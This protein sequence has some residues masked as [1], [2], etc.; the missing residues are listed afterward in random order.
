[1]SQH[2]FETALGRLICDD[3]FRREF[4]DDPE[5]A[6]IC[7][8]FELTSIELHSLCK[9]NS[10]AVDAFVFHVDDRVRRAAEP[11]IE[12]TGVAGPR[13]LPRRSLG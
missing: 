3:G 12:C 7:R 5:K 2:A 8:G 6:I 1:M 13:T 9:I 11:L 4:Y 10:G